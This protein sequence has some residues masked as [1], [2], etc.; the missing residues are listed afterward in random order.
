MGESAK[1][2]RQKGLGKDAYRTEEGMLGVWLG[3]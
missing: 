3:A 1:A 2:L